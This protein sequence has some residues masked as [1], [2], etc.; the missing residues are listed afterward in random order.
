MECRV[1]TGETFVV[2]P[3]I[4]VGLRDCHH[5]M[6]HRFCTFRG[7]IRFRKSGFV[8]GHRDSRVL[9]SDPRPTLH[10]SQNKKLQ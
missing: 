9:K 4:G 8:S 5:A 2:S 1:D 10:C 6:I 3:E 7:R